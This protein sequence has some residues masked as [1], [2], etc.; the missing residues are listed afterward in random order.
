MADAMSAA[1]CVLHC[2]EIPQRYSSRGSPRPKCAWT[3]VPHRGRVRL[4][5]A[6]V[7]SGTRQ[8]RPQGLVSLEDVCAAGC[9]VQKGGRAG[10]EEGELGE[11]AAIAE[12]RAVLPCCAAVLPGFARSPRPQRLW[13]SSLLV[14]ATQHGAGCGVLFVKE[15]GAGGRWS[16]VRWE[17]HA[18]RTPSPLL[19]ISVGNVRWWGVAM[20]V[21]SAPERGDGGEGAPSAR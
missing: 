1:Q 20:A 10:C 5:G 18:L 6:C 2:N 8:R 4:G 14:P 17:Q 19:R 7:R 3:S 9:A 12:E 16:R 21:G 13:A 15:S 11:H